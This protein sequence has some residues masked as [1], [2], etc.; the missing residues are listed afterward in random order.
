LGA[1]ATSMQ[2]H[3]ECGARCNVQLLLRPS[4]TVA[5]FDMLEG[6]SARRVREVLPANGGI[7]HAYR[8]MLLLRRVHRQRLHVHRHGVAA[9]AKLRDCF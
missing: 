3:I 1:F 9:L 4:A 5:F 2:R 7:D 8:D 6:Y